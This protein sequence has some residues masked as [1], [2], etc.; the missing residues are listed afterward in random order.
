MVIVGAAMR[1]LLQLVYGVLKSGMPFDPNYAGSF[2]ISVIPSRCSVVSQKVQ[3][4][5]SLQDQGKDVGKDGS[6]YASRNSDV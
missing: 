3:K 5:E 4:G 2:R 1:K 6:S